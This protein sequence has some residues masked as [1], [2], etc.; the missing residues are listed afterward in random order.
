MKRKS[1][2]FPPPNITG[3]LH[4]GHGFQQT[5][6]DIF[7]RYHLRLG[8]EVLWQPGTD[9]AGIASQVLLEKKLLKEN[10][11]C[12]SIGRE[13]TRSM[14][15]DNHK[16]ASSRIRYQMQRLG[17][18]V[19]WSQERFTMDQDFQEAVQTCFI[20]LYDDGLIFRSKRMIHWDTVLGTALS[21]AEVINKEV[22]G[23]MYVLRYF[24]VDSEAHNHSFLSVCTTRPETLF[25][26]TA[27]AVHPDDERYKNIV[28]SKVYV[29]IINREIPIITSDVVDVTKGTGCL[30]IT[31]GHDFND[32]KVALKHNLDIIE[33]LDDRGIF[34]NKELLGMSV[35]EGRS[36]TL[37]MLV[38]HG[39][40]LDILQHKHFVPTGDRSG[41]VL[42]PKLTTQWFIDSRPMFAKIDHYVREGKI[43]IFPKNWKK[44]FLKIL[45]GD[46]EPWCISRQIYWGHKIPVWYDEDQNVYVGKSEE[47]IREKYNLKSDIT[48]DKDVL[49]T[50][51]SSA[52]WPIVTLG[53]P[54]KDISPHYPHS[55]VITGFDILFFWVFRMLMFGI[56]FTGDVPFENVMLTGL[57]RDRSGNKMS[58]SKGNVI[59]FL[60]IIDGIE[61]DQ[62]LEKR[63]ADISDIRVRDNIIKETSKDFPEGIKEYGADALRFALAQGAVP[64]ID[65]NFDFCRLRTAEYLINKIKN[66]SRFIVLMSEKYP[67]ISGQASALHSWISD[68]F[69][70]TRHSIDQHVGNYRFD[71]VASDLYDFICND[72]CGWYIELLKAQIKVSDIQEN[73][74]LAHEMISVFLDILVLFEPIMPF[75]ANSLQLQFPDFTAHYPKFRE[76]EHPSEEIDFIKKIISEI[77]SFRAE[78]K[79]WKECPLTVESIDDINLEIVRKYDF[80]IKHMAKIND[81]SFDPDK[82]FN[83]KFCLQE[84]TFSIPISQDIEKTKKLFTSL[85]KEKDF[86]MARLANEEFLIKAPKEI[87]NTNKIRLSEIE[88]QMKKAEEELT[89]AENFD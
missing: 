40:L 63:L 32:Y 22:E 12:S 82:S 70:K 9:H 24:F 86:L 57:I 6:M 34:I 54:K 79:I 41:S 39:H 28:G 74:V 53:W 8:S 16:E 81:I 64:S 68:S 48:Q 73:R 45:D 18:S 46:L 43:S 30:K 15:F 58:K 52:L 69:N 2:V 44:D 67:P 78:N 80:L 51:F 5:L 19:D 61:L 56:H 36:H 85:S 37:T 66:S 4:M 88:Q 3:S 49:D 21:N 10:K 89:E 76:V 7:A 31:P 60:D 33:L 71:L 47:A 50:W 20:K 35:L 14:I 55:I 26:D 23:H 84:V 29:P 65:I 83:K 25:G 27:I 72:F 62:L 38:D 13:M 77:R 42:E 59:D 75:L 11:S 1:I 17:L 87:I